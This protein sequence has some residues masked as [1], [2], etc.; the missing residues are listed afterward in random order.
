MTFQENAKLYEKMHVRIQ[1]ITKI[2][3]IDV[4]CVII[5]RLK[6]IQQGPI[7]LE[8]INLPIVPEEIKLST[9]TN[10]KAPEITVKQYIFKNFKNTDDKNNKFHIETLRDILADNGFDVGNKITTL[11]TKLQIGIHNNNVTIDKIKK[12]GF[13]NMIYSQTE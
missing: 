4:E 1:E 3:N 10:N 5:H 7:V 11:F 13:T 2:C 12:Q 8:E 9:E 6:F